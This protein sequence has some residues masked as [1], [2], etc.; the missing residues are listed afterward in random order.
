MIIN[1]D[2]MMKVV[3]WNILMVCAVR[4]YVAMWILCGM[5]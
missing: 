3:Q 2:K 4:T 1:P 5:T